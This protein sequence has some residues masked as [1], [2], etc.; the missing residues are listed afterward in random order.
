VDL[1]GLTVENDDSALRL[2]HAVMSGTSYKFAEPKLPS[3]REEVILALGALDIE[4]LLV[5]GVLA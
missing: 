5:H 2:L 3:D 4:T 1:V